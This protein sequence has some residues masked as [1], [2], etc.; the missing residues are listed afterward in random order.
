[1]AGVVVL[2]AGGGTVFVAGF[3]R[4]SALR[5]LSTRFTLSAFRRLSARVDC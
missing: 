1:V 2:V 5:M 3:R 4:L